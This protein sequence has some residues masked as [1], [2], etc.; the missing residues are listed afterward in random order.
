[1]NKLPLLLLACLPL[2]LLAAESG[3]DTAALHA[4]ASRI[5]AQFV[6]QLKPELQAAMKAGGPTHAIAVCAEKAPAI[7]RQLSRETGW[8]VKRVSL[9]SRNQD[10]ARP[11]P[12][13]RG[14]LHAFDQS[15]VDEIPL[16]AHSDWVGGEFRFIKP[17]PVEG[18]CLICHGAELTPEVT[19]ALSRHYPWDTATGYAL[20]EVRGGIS[21]RWP[22]SKTDQEYRR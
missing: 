15:V 9:K 4:E 21:L 8:S 10:S 11:D 18:I 1:M 12:W 22:E 16:D 14:H 20:G 6:G 13:E 3:A 2:R 5:A 19:N 17:Q 7:A